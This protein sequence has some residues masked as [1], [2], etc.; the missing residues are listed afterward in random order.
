TFELI[1]EVIEDFAPDAVISD[2]ECWTSH[3]AAALKI[4]R[5]GI[6][7]I[8]IM[9]YCRPEL[10]GWDRLTTWF[11]TSVYRMLM[12]QP[13]RVIVSSFFDAAPRDRR[14]R[15]VGTLVR[16]AV[17]S[18]QPWDGDHLL[19]Y[20]NRGHDQL[21]DGVVRS[22]GELDCPIRVYGAPHRGR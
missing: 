21:H 11:D 8:G 3:V 7:H 1:R 12:G 13:D 22:L 20:F 14:V 18:L 16:D 17:R 4:P 9:T 5:I 19:V 6:D 10:S 15:V 2:A